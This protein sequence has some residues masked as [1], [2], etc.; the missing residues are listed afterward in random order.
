MV[1][2]AAEVHREAEVSRREGEEHRVA[3]V[4]AVALVL[5]RTEEEEVVVSAVVV[6]VLQEGGAASEDKRQSRPASEYWRKMESVAFRWWHELDVSF[7]W[8]E[9]AGRTLLPAQGIL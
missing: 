1:V 5:A 2:E 8:M 3:E 7:Y 9:F 4:E 6:E